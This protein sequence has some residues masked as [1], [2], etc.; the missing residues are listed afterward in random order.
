MKHLLH[1]ALTL[2]AALF[3]LSSTAQLQTLGLFS[4]TPASQ[5][6]YVLFAP[7][8]SVNT[9]LIDKCG[10]RIH[11]WASSR[12]P[13]LSTYLLEDGSL[14]RTECLHNSNF[15][16]G[17]TGGAIARYDWSGNLMWSYTLSSSMECQHHD[18][19]RLPNGNILAIVWDRKMPQEAIDAGRD[20]AHVG[21]DLWSEKIVELQPVGT[22]SANIVWEWRVWDHLV[23]DFD[24]NR[25]NYGSVKDNP[26][27]ININ[28]YGA[29]T[30]GIAD[31]LH[32]N[33]IDYNPDL[34]QI[35][36]SVR[37]FSEIWIIDHSVTNAE[38][39][40]HIGGRH[41]VGGDLLYRWGNPAAYDRGSARD[42]QLFGQ[43]NSRWITGPRSDSGKIMVFNNG[44]VRLQSNSTVDV[45]AP[46]ILSDGSYQSSGNAAYGPQS[47]FW[48][49][50]AP[51]SMNFFS[52]YISGA[53][54]LSNGNTLICEGDNG[55]FFEVDGKG[56]VVWEY[57]NPIGTITYVQGANPNGTNNVF[58]CSQYPVS[59]PAFKGRVMTPGAP[60]E[61][62]PK[63]Y[64]CTMNTGSG[65]GGGSGGGGGS[66][67]GVA[68]IE[69]DG[70]LIVAANP[71]GNSLSLQS[72]QPLQA[73]VLRLTDITGAVCQTWN[74]VEFSGAAKLRL[75]LSKPL[76]PGLYLLHISAPDY[77]QVIKLV[78]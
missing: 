6:G 7:M 31:W 1:T 26:G 73:A 44:L 38:A 66:T 78:H 20:T 71:F 21:A 22:N 75:N 65:S 30:P 4:R 11:S 39:A 72:S 27:L 67:N 74:N 37:T 70:S 35:M 69:N 45:I 18:I 29:G 33:S 51:A 3:S 76:A 28:F 64:T 15:S 42:Q 25:F 59:Y 5:D 12:T 23:Q 8:T 52:A 10:K 48:Q 49:Y 77:Q 63:S 62:N 17:G 56:N 16:T 34:D 53:Q 47:L 57:V 41:G 60:L 46:P 13:A 61:L 19:C 2:F 55:R 68:S 24:P 40:G 14:L 58:R 54:P 36:L 32:I 50:A 43:H 9:Y